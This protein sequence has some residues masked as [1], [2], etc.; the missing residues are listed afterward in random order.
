MKKVSGAQCSLA[1]MHRLISLRV[2]KI[3]L[4]EIGPLYSL[5][6]FDHNLVILFSGRE[7]YL[8]DLFSRVKVAM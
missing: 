2:S 5:I 6:G 3:N 7:F 4:I 8:A 1:C